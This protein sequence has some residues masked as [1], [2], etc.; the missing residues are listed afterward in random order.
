MFKTM[1]PGPL[2]TLHFTRIE[3]GTV[4]IVLSNVKVTKTP[5]D[6]I[7]LDLDVHWDGQCDIELDANMMPKVVCVLDF[8]YWKKTL[9]Q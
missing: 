9:I 1:L 5:Q 8:S 7:R 6:G 4:P 2:A 3:L